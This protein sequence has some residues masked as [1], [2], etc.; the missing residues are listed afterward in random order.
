[1]QINKK[2]KELEEKLPYGSYTEIAKRAKTTPSKVR[3]FFKLRKKAKADAI[4]LILPIAI[5][6]MKELEEIINK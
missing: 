5:D 2:I 6:Y 4:K 3:D 1:M